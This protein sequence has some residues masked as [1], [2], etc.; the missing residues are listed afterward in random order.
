[1]SDFDTND[2]FLKLY[3]SIIPFNLGFLFFKEERF[4]QHNIAV[5]QQIL[6]V[7]RLPKTLLDPKKIKMT[8][9]SSGMRS[10]KSDEAVI[11]RYD[12]TQFNDLTVPTSSQEDTDD[13]SDDLITPEPDEYVEKIEEA[14]VSNLTSV[15]TTSTSPPRTSTTIPTIKQQQSVK[16][17]TKKGLSVGAKVGIGFGVI[18]VV[19]IAYHVYTWKKKKQQRR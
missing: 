17:T 10:T 13:T 8:S 16:K 3:Q 2:K 15:A 4:L 7:N 11:E 19:V 14:V 12:D 6:R 9:I 18:A 1:M 5:L